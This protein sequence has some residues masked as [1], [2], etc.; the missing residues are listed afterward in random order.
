ML[1]F[2]TGWTFPFLLERDEQGVDHRVDKADVESALK[3]RAQYWVAQ[4]EHT[5]SIGVQQDAMA[6]LYL[7]AGDVAHAQ[8]TFDARIATPGITLADRS[9]TLLRAVQLLA[10]AHDTVRIRLALSYQRQLD[11]LPAAANVAKYKGRVMLGQA[12][13][14]VGDGSSAVSHLLSALALI[15][16]IPFEQRE[17]VM[18]STTRAT[19]ALTMITEIWSADSTMHTRTDSLGAYLLAQFKATPEQLARDKDL[20]MSAGYGIRTSYW[21]EAVNQILARNA[22][23]GRPAPPAVATHW[24][25]AAAPVT[26]NASAPGAKQVNSGDGVIRVFEFGG[27]GCSACLEKLP[28]ME[29]IRARFNGAVGV[30]YMAKAEQRWGATDCTPDESAEHIRK[31]YVVH[32][33]VTLPIGVWAPPVDDSTTE[34]GALLARKHPTFDAY[35]IEGIPVFVVVDGHGI[36]RKFP[37]SGERFE[38]DLTS[39]LRYLLAEAQRNPATTANQ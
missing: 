26:P 29:R 12:Y 18:S 1:N 38:E 27:L 30:W 7:A 31:Y 20:H 24:Y 36:V 11:A 4:F 5:S 17:E 37:L 19:N 9:Y 3:R 10:D 15:H 25:N 6:E 13:Y 23:V 21:T 22:Y 32:H 2:Y 33:N 35:K 28:I 14:N 16:D 8:R 34:P 39:F